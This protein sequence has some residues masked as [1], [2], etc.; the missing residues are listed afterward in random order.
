MDASHASAADP[1]LAIVAR[2]LTKRFEVPVRDAGLA[3]SLRALV[4][5]R[6]R[7]VHAVES[8]DIEIRRGEV[9]GFL[10]PNGAGKTTTLKMLSGLLHPS[11]GT[12][13]V[14]GH[15]PHR[16]ERAFLERISLVMGQRQQLVWDLPTA[17]SLQM[18]RA[19]YDLEPAA[20]QAQYAELDELLELAPLVDKPV[21]QLSLGERMKCELAAGL[22]HRPDVLFL[23]EPTLGLDVQAQRRV[24]EFVASY[25]ERSGATVLLTSHYMADI[26]ALAERVI[27]IHHGHLQF[28]GALR[29]LAARTSDRKLVTVRLDPALVDS[30]GDPLLRE[31]LVRCGDVVSTDGCEAVVEVPRAEVRARLGMLLQHEQVLDFTVEDEP[32]ERVME[33]VFEHARPGELTDTASDN[34]A[35][36]AAAAVEGRT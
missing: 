10:G 34:A 24:R 31:L 3:A 20:Y 36:V 1:D 6:T 29:E 35:V 12:A 26:E 33:R 14:L 25:A 5:R 27:V 11:A 28:D 16:R 13:R 7:T 8:V 17:D 32:I 4:Q 18:L 19:I 22:L 9:V 15:V 2:G 30:A 23:D 21:R